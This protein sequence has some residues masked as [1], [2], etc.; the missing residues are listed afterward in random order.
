MLE[1]WLKNIIAAYRNN[2]LEFTAIEAQL[3][4]RLRVPHHENA[5]DKQIAA[6]ALAYDLCLVTRNTDDFI[7]TGAR[8]IN[9]FV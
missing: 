5:L 3:W 6:T 7:G 2:I 4:G 1:S 8:V 9:P